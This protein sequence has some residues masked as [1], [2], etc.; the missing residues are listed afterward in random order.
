MGHSPCYSKRRS[1]TG[2]YF[3]TVLG[4]EKKVPLSAVIVVDDLKEAEDEHPRSTSSVKRQRKLM[5]SIEKSFKTGD[6]SSSNREKVRNSARL[7]STLSNEISSVIQNVKRNIPRHN[8]DSIS[9][10]NSVSSEEGFE[11]DSEEYSNAPTRISMTSLNKETKTTC[12]NIV[13]ETGDDLPEHSGATHKT[14]IN[15]VSSDPSSKKKISLSAWNGEDS[16]SR[17]LG[18]SLNIKQGSIR[19]KGKS[20]LSSLEDMLQK[21]ASRKAAACMQREVGVKTEDGAGTSGNESKSDKNLSG[22]KINHGAVSILNIESFEQTNSMAADG[23]FEM[24]CDAK[25]RLK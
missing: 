4:M 8:T 13:S 20:F 9:S 21:T 19:K 23:C 3:R 17:R 10:E 2:E 5:K 15:S 1:L 6:S 18:R 25:T 14:R 12:A 22:I 7:W 11:E 24:D 16:L